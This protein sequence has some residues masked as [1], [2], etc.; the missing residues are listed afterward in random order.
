MTENKPALGEG[1]L[2]AAVAAGI[3]SEAQA[4]SVMALAAQRFAGRP[5]A[6]DE[7]FELFRGFAEIFVSLGLLIL[8]AGLLV[9][10]TAADSLT[11]F[12]MIGVIVSIALA[13]YF[14]LKRRMVLPSILLV[15]AYAISGFGVILGLMLDRW[16]IS[17]E[18]QSAMV[19][20]SGTMMAALA[21]WYWRFKLPFTMLLIALWG[22]VFSVALIAPNDLSRLFDADDLI[23][24]LRLTGASRFGLATLLAGLAA[25]AGGLWFDLRDRF[26]LGRAA[27]SGFWL[28]LVGAPLI[29][30]TLAQ[31]ALTMGDSH[32][33]LPLA[34][35]LAVMTL[36]ALIIDRRSF[37]TA[38]LGY[39]IWL[40]WALAYRDGAGLDW[41]AILILIGGAV[42]AL[43]AWWVPLR[44]A[45]M[46]ALPEFPGKDRL[47]PYLK[48]AR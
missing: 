41:P 42:T 36:F 40:I 37:L 16:G 10:A 29:V 35:V 14:T 33:H 2:R 27:A 32:G 45:L 3:L 4:A 25:S 7:A 47:P 48:G 46:R 21:A 26:R 8:M 44:A 1:D 5:E 30:N 18:P 31:T 20:I 38:G 9:L 39:L 23:E 43:G 34:L 19:V 22:F 15:C 12:S 11:G 17:L 13:H 28:H 24:G 6:D